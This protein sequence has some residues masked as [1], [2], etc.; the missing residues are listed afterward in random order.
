MNDTPERWLPIPG[1]EGLYDVSDQGRVRSW[2]PWHGTPVPRVLALNLTG[3]KGPRRYLGAILCDKTSARSMKKAH[4][5]VLLA[6]VGP[7]P[8]DLQARHLDSNSTNNALT[9]LIY[10]TGTENTLD[11]IAHGT[12]RYASR[13]HC[14][15]GHLYDEAN[16][17]R[18]SNGGRRCRTCIRARYTKVGT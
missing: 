16:T 3:P 7:R 17:I 18:R 6:F 12:H 4:L 5:L 14:E 11:K 10:G 13:T 8:A 1:Y 9:N 15:H 2:H